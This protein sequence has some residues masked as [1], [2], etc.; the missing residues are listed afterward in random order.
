M[1]IVRHSIISN[2]QWFFVNLTANKKSC[3]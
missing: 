3:L 1:R 2:Y